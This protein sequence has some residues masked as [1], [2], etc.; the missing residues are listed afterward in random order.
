MDALQTKR[1][2]IRPFTAADVATAHQVLDLEMQWD[3]DN[4]S[5]QERAQIL[6]REILLANWHDGSRLFGARG[7]F[8]VKPQFEAGREAIGKGGLLRDPGQASAIADDLKLWLGAQAGWRAVGP[9]A[10]PIE[11]GDGNVE[12]LIGGVKRS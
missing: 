5:R 7:I 4:V 2:L 12:Y 3:G 9:V 8:L 1:L 10:S 11:G 6:Q